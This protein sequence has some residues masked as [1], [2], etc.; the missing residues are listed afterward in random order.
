MNQRPLKYEY[1]S[2]NEETGVRMVRREARR[3]AEALKTVL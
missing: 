1:E 3:G 2:K